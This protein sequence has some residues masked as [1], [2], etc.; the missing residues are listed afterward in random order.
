MPSPRRRVLTGIALLLAIVAGLDSAPAAETLT[1]EE[2]AAALR[3]AVGF[4][5]DEVSVQGGYVWRYS[6]DLSRREGEGKADATTAWVQPPGTPSV[7]EAL[8]AAY[9]TCGEPLCLEAAR[10]TAR[11]L[12]LGQ[13]RSGGWDYRIEFDPRQRARIAYRVNGGSRNARNVTTFDDETSQSAL[14]FLIRIDEVL[15]FKDDS[16]HEAALFGLD[17]VLKAQ[18]PNGGWPQRYSEF[19]NPDEYPVKP[20]QFPESWSRT[21]PK[22]DYRDYYTLNDQLIP[23]M[24]T[25]LFEAERVYGDRKYRAAA[26]K[27]GDF[28]ILAQLP[29]PQP[30]WAQ[31]YDREMQPAWARR[32]EPPAVTGGESQGALRTL[33]QLYRVTGNRKYLEPVPRALAYLRRSELENGRLARFYELKTNRP[34]FL[35]TN[36]ELTYSRDDLPTHYG[37]IVES[38]VDQI[39]AEYQKLLATPPEK[40]NPPPRKRRFRKSAGLTERAR[41]IIKALDERGAWVETGQLRTEKSDA[42][43]PIISTS[44]FI[45]NSAVLSQFLA[46]E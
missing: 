6:A 2:A 14:R 10:Q 9:E 31:Q 12:V 28:L 18:Y 33:L 1:K 45:R 29:E 24:L 26:E 38:K 17:A 5:R 19:P 13:L 30:A 21:Y 36:Y 27:A 39:E 34:L 23:D 42:A 22:A 7:G 3:R 44:T 11:A 16:I 4:F 46:A 8:L 41:S 20:A 37:F 43:E 32:F 40:L 35:T 15:E 25:V